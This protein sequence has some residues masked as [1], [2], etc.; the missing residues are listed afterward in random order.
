MPARFQ[1]SPHAPFPTGL[2]EALCALSFFRRRHKWKERGSRGGLLRNVRI[3]D[4]SHYGS[5]VRE[6]RRFI[7]AARALGWRGSV[8]VAV[9]AAYATPAP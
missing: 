7:R 8:T 9:S 4:W 5:Y 1:S 2:T 6:A 3:K